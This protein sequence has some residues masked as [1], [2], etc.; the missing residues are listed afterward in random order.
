MKALTFT[1]NGY[2]LS[3]EMQEEFE[4]Q[5]QWAMLLNEDGRVVWSIRRPE[6]LET[7]YS[8]LPA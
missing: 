8:R 6:E 2:V 7:E 5:D 3:E 4:R 1:K